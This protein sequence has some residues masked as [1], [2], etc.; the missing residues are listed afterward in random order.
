MAIPMIE[1]FCL[2][3]EGP[4]A[5]KNTLHAAN[6]ALMDLYGPNAILVP[7]GPGVLGL[8]SDAPR[9]TTTDDRVAYNCYQAILQADNRIQRMFVTAPLAYEGD[10][11]QFLTLAEQWWENQ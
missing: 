9:D 11:E 7:V 3:N 2:P 6:I 1:L 10:P 5:E 4:E 8:T